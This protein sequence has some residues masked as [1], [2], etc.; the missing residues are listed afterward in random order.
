MTDEHLLT[1]ETN[2]DHDRLWL[3][4]HCGWRCGSLPAGSAEEGK[5]SAET[6]WLMGRDHLETVAGEDA[7]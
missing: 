3:H 1:M 2:A 6:L 7:S 5:R 4:C